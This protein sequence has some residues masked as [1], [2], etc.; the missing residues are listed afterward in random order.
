[1]ALRCPKSL[2]NQQLHLILYTGKGFITQLMRII[3]TYHS[4]KIHRLPALMLALWLGGIGC[5]LGCEME[6]SAA[7]V[8]EAQSSSSTT[9]CPA[10]SGSN[11]CHQRASKDGDGYSAQTVPQSA[12]A[13]SCCLLAAQPAF[14]FSKP[15]VDSSALA[16]P[17]HGTFPVLHAETYTAPS[18]NRLFVRNRGGTYLLCCVFLI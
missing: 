3:K 12:D 10:L 8:N 11:C 14:V 1:M 17:A 4:R 13:I 16:L 18:A 7:P 5:L 6:V 9:S 2:N 15:Q